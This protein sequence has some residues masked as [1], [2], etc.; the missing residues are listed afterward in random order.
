MK[1]GDTLIANTEQDFC[2]PPPFFF[3]K[4]SFFWPCLKKLAL[5]LDSLAE[6]PSWEGLRF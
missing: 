5:G 3:F 6:E 1:E 2:S 4:N